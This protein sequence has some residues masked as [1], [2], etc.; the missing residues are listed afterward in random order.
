MKDR[1]LEKQTQWGPFVVIVVVAWG[2]RLPGFL[3]LFFKEK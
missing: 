1:L 3:F 2:R